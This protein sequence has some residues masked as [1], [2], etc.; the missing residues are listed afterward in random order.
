[1]KHWLQSSH[2][3]VSYLN[4]QYKA[5]IRW[6]QDGLNPKYISNY[7]PKKGGGYTGIAG[8]RL[9]KYTKDAGGT[10]EVE[11]NYKD[12]IILLNVLKD[13]KFEFYPTYFNNF[14]S[15]KIEGLARPPLHQRLLLYPTKEVAKAVELASKE[16]TD[17]AIALGEKMLEETK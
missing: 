14:S 10:I 17:L 8:P 11:D 6:S 9:V 7:S 1:M 12:P 16:T 3:Y 4:G 2:S 5:I 13:L 15:I